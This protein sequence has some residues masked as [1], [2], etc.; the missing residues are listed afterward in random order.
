MTK[1]LG[2]CPCPWSKW[3]VNSH[4][5]SCLG[6]GVLLFLSLLTK[7]RLQGVQGLDIP[8]NWCFLP[9]RNHRLQKG[10]M[11]RCFETL[12]V[13][14]WSCQASQEKNSDMDP[15]ICG[16]HSTDEHSGNA[17]FF[18]TLWLGEWSCLST[19]YGTTR[20][21]FPRNFDCCF[22]DLLFPSLLKKPALKSPKPALK[23]PNR[24]LKKKEA[25]T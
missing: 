20:R 10:N 24:T 8:Q 4:L 13:G 23:R 7:V 12:G 21:A 19:I 1:R 18:K 25:G 14:E 16:T 17:T 15:A 22:W 3:S 6:D 5:R 11:R 2:G 9:C